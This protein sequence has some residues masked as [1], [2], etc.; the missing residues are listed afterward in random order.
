MTT[1]EPPDQRR[2]G[3][4][5][6]GADGALAEPA[7]QQAGHNGDS[8][9]GPPA[10]ASQ[11]PRQGDA[12]EG[13]G[14]RES[15]A[16]IVAETLGLAP[17]SSRRRRAVTLLVMLSIAL[18]A[19]FRD[20]L[21]GYLMIKPSVGWENDSNAEY[22][23][24][25]VPF[26]VSVRPEEAEPETWAV[27]LDRALTL[28]EK[29]KLVAVEN[30]RSGAFSYLK[31]LGGRPLADR[32][33]LEKAPERYKDQLRSGALGT[34]ADVFQMNVMSTRSTAVTINGW[35]TTDVVCRK[36]TGHTIVRLPEQGGASYEGLQLHIPPLVD[37]PV[38]TDEIEGQGESYFST[39]V[40]E[41]GGGQ[42]SGNYKVHAIAPPG[43]SC[44]WGIKLHYTDAY[45]TKRWVQL[46]D[47]NGKP[48]RIR[49]DSV[50]TDARQTWVF[51]VQPWRLCD[52]S[53]KCIV[54]PRT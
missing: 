35:Q 26:T 41:V 1:T 43:K 23:A 53:W 11:P 48:L 21:T 7:P 3:P 6:G 5:P 15:F 2:D 13:N 46:K 24:N 31:K 42:P 25:K 52:Q 28:E 17:G 32:A 27:V 50:P 16:S 18:M 51:I 9:D 14:A 30:D 37:E 39:H 38:L 29:Q 19:V 47:G 12:D 8:A 34:Y 54:H 36:S 44:Q 45:Q 49:T 33:T 40:I 10:A 4:Q 22:D 20:T